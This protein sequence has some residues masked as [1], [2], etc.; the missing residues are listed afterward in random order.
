MVVGIYCIRNKINNKYYIGQSVNIK[1]RW[2]EH[3]YNLRHNRHVNNKLQNAWNKYGENAFE[4]KII[5]ACKKQY[6]DRFEKLYMSTFNTHKNGYNI[7]PG[8]YYNPMLCEECRS[9]VSQS[10]M[11]ENNHM[12]GKKHDIASEILMS[13]SKNTSGYFRVDK[14]KDKNAKQ[15][16]YW[17]YQYYDLDGKKKSIKSANIDKLKNKVQKLGLDW[18]EISPT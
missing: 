14:Y 18:Y 17:R 2:K 7:I 6:L 11:G 5:K 13:K 16:F 8:G 15:G 4:F 9:K 12:Y 10:N 3:K 1:N